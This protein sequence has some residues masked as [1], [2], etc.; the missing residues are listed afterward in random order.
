MYVVVNVFLCWRSSGVFSCSVSFVFGSCC[1]SML[2]GVNDDA[3]MMLITCSLLITLCL[4]GTSR[5][6]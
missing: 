6:V 4:L 1:V 2:I 5:F 3:G